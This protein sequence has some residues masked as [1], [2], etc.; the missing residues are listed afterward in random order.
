MLQIRHNRSLESLPALLFGTSHMRK[1]SSQMLVLVFFAS[2]FALPETQG[3]EV[4]LNE[5]NAVSEEDY[6]ANGNHDPAFGDAP[7]RGNGGSWVELVIVGSDPLSGSPTGTTVDMRGWTLRW[8]FTKGTS[9]HKDLEP[10]IVTGDLQLSQH[11]LWANLRSGTILTFTAKN[12]AAGG[13]D[14]KTVI[15]PAA[16][17]WHI[18]IWTGD[19]QFVTELTEPFMTNHRDWQITI[20]DASGHKVFGP[21]GEGINPNKGVGRDEVCKLEEISVLNVDPVTSVYLDGGT[22]T[23]GRPNEWAGGQFEQDLTVLRSWVASGN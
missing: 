11:S 14:T 18:N 1:I 20:L 21:A 7:V 6:L 12:N 22:S 2:L 4:I 23:F 15:Q 8:Q 10:E 3:A 5:F 17:D 16:D 9:K 13:M 19:N